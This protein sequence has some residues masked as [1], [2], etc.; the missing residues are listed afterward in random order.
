[1][2]TETFGDQLQALLAAEDAD[3]LLNSQEV[4]EDLSDTLTLKV[5]LDSPEKDQWIDAI[6]SEL[7]NIKLEDVYELVDPNS[8]KIENLLGNKIVL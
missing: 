2:V 4:I 3:H 5:A 8:E 1:M 7:N 6:H